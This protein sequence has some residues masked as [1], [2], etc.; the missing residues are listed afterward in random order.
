MET[1]GIENSPV[2]R[3]CRRVWFRS[4][5]RCARALA[6]GQSAWEAAETAIV[7]MV[8]EARRR[9][10]CVWTQAGGG[11]PIR[12]VA[13]TDEDG[14]GILIESRN[15]HDAGAGGGAAVG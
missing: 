4:G 15:S 2:R 5:R 10:V 6:G 14:S 11:R 12:D 8:P 13:S 1:R 9:E 3:S 7:P